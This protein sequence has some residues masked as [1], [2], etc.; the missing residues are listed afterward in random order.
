M[1]VGAQVAHQFGEQ[2]EGRVERREVGELRADVHV[3]AGDLQP[4]QA[5]GAGVDLARQRQRHAEFVFLFAGGDFG[6]RFRVHVG[7]H[8]QRDFRAPTARRRD[9][10]DG[11]ELGLG[12]DVETEN[13][14]VQR[15]LDLSRGL[16]DAGE[17]DFSRSHA[18]F[19]RARQFAAGHHVHAGPERGQQRQHGLIGIGLH[20]VADQRVEPVERL[21]EDREMAADGRGRI[22]VERRFDIFGQRRQGDVLG[23]EHA[24]LI[25]EMMHEARFREWGLGRRDSPRAAD[26]RRRPRP[27]AP[28]A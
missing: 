12:F 8:P 20:R 28:W 7:V 13:P 16:A 21:G 6:V 25:S 11:F 10:G 5:G 2:A 24:V 22:A 14:G 27:A 17:G 18:G 23:V 26:G 1:A 9:G 19:Q 3:D 15:R 4:R